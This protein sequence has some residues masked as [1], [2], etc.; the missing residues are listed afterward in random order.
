MNFGSTL[1]EIQESSAIVRPE[2]GSAEARADGSELDGRDVVLRG[3]DETDDF[4]AALRAAAEHPEVEVLVVDLQRV[5]QITSRA[6]GA[7]VDATNRLLPRGGR[8]AVAGA[9][10]RIQKVMDTLK[11][12]KLIAS[13]ES[14]RAAIEAK[15]S[16]PP[17]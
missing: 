1:L 8:V 15:G 16:R 2:A 11:L 10:A 9:S 13:F 3:G 5:R 14:T 4:I 6:L 17:E 12:S 7:M